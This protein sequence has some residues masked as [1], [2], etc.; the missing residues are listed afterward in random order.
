MPPFP[1]T[2][3]VTLQIFIYLF[4]QKYLVEGCY[5][6]PCPDIPHHL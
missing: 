6:S 4:I 3:I 5:S 1:K 2:Q